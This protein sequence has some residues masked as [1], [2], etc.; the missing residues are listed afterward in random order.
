MAAGGFTLEPK[1]MDL[2]RAVADAAA[3][4]QDQ[5]IRGNSRIDVSAP[6]PVRG[7]WDP[8][9]ID[10]VI[11]NL[12]SNAIKFGAG[13][14]VVAVVRRSGDSAR[15]EMRDQ[16]PGLA[17]ADRDRIFERFER[18]VSDLSYGGLGLGLWIARQIAVAHGGRIGVESSAGAGAT[19][20]VELPL[21]ERIDDASSAG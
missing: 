11:T 16:G 19:F 21:K 14:P 1:P 4:L 12:L 6:E 8:T 20:F 17:E 2:S 5:A 9:A 15:L 18:G 13:K 3:R 10:Q 7:R